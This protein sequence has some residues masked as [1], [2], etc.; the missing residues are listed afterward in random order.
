MLILAMWLSSP[1]R[2]R[3]VIHIVIMW[4]SRSSERVPSLQK[5]VQFECGSALN[6]YLSV[7]S[8][9]PMGQCC[10]QGRLLA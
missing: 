1:N 10:T 7:V 3:A 8:A 6:S 9:W 2:A 4:L 5:L